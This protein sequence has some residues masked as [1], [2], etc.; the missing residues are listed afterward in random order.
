[1]YCSAILERYAVVGVFIPCFV[2]RGFALDLIR[3]INPIRQYSEYKKSRGMSRVHDWI[4]WLGGYPFEVAKPEQIFEFFYRKGYQ[5]ESLTTCGRGLG[6][7]EFVFRK[8]CQTE[9]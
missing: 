1:M 5:L 4:D 7:N 2:L 9:H 8:L 3:G 6:C